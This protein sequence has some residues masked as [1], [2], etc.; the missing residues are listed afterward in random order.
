MLIEKG[1][2]PLVK[3]RNGR[4]VLQ[5]VSIF[6]NSGVIQSL[7]Q[8]ARWAEEVDLALVSTSTRN[9][10]R[11]RTHL[12]S[13]IGT[14]NTALHLAAMCCSG[15]EFGNILVELFK[16][17]GAGAPKSEW[18]D[19]KANQEREY[20]CSLQNND[21][22]TVLHRAIESGNLEV[23]ELIC[24]TVPEV[25]TRLD[26]LSRSTVWHAASSGDT[27]MLKAVMKAYSLCKNP[28]Y[29]HL[30]DDNGLTPLHVACWRGHLKFVRELLNCGGIQYR[31]TTFFGFTPAELAKKNGQS[32][33]ANFLEG[34]N[35][36]DVASCKTLSVTHQYAAFCCSS[37]S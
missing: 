3:A 12:G 26:N 1:L 8:K 18:S 25:A 31:M 36:I 29:F 19:T 22:E 34:L 24:R 9:L 7:L 6:G 16:A 2:D 32:Y 4:N 28:P 37:T 14:G 20:L 10:A 30:S 33:V 35:L 17:T 13:E 5:L 23:V 27:Q 15:E 21:G 11:I